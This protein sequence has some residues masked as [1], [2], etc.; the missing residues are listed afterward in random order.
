MEN[1]QN[2]N[3]QQSPFT[4]YP[5]SQ[6]SG[7]GACDPK[8]FDQIPAPPGFPTGLLLWCAGTTVAGDYPSMLWSP[9]QLPV[10]SGYT[11]LHLDVDVIL[12]AALLAGAQCLE[13]DTVVTVD[14]VNYLHGFHLLLRENGLAQ[15]SNSEGN[16]WLDAE[17]SVEL[18]PDVVHHFTF[19][20][21][22]DFAAQT[23]TWVGI[24]VDGKPYPVPASVNTVKGVNLKWSNGYKVQLQLDNPPAA[25]LISA[26]FD[27]VN[28]TWMP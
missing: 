12:S 18:T 11:Q 24:S 22:Y 27:N 23:A 16:Q 1:V 20:Y 5:P 25:P 9:S 28:Y 13:M 14:G 19:E 3:I 10:P 6:H 7:I 21:K 4:E 8:Y 15:V 17:F 2:L 26:V